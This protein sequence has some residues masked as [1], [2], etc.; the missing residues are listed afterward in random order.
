MKAK[1]NHVYSTDLG[2]RTVDSGL[3]LSKPDKP[4][5]AHRGIGYFRTPIGKLILC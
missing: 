4:A 5:P 1:G 3:L 2:L